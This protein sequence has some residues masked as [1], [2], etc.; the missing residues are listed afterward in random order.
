MRGDPQYLAGQVL[1]VVVLF[2]A[3][4]S[5]GQDPAVVMSPPEHFAMRVV[6]SGL[7]GPWE[8]AWGPDN[9]LWVTERQGRRVVRINPLDG[10][11]STAVTIPE[12]HQ[13]VTQ[14]GLLGLALHPELLRGTG[15]DYVYVAFT[16]DDA[17]GTALLR[18]MV[19]RRYRYDQ[20]A[21]RLTEP[22]DLL[23]GLPVH[24]D[25]VGGRLAFG[26]DLKLYLTIGDQG[27]NFGSNR[28]NLNRAQ[29]LPAAADVAC[30]GLDP[31]PGEDSAGRARRI[32]PERQSRDCRCPQPC[33]FL[34]PPK[35]ARLGI[36]Q[37]RPVVRVGT[38]AEHRR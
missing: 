16:Y 19:I 6:A 2:A 13:S 3:A 33:V 37:E 20:P 5:A 34:R 30:E 38:R 7:E 1:A 21:G 32:D 26:P 36:R 22:V 23:T 11:K 31:L 12:V 25:H 15:N 27:S 28:C 9:Q 18:K 29:E 35:S 8:V 17:P 10:A 14:D 4:M 24:D